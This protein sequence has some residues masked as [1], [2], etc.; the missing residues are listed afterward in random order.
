MAG[1]GRSSGRGCACRSRLL[2]GSG[3][4]VDAFAVSLGGKQ[5]RPVKT[6]LRP[7]VLTSVG[8]FVPVGPIGDRTPVPADG[9]MT[10]SEGKR[11]GAKW[12]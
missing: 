10:L 6:R 11:S 7:P 5:V 4:G 3:D 12:R 1:S 8:G 9:A 2:S